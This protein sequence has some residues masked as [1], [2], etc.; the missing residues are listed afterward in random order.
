[1]A[2][3]RIDPLFER[4]LAKLDATIRKRTA[5]ALER[6]VANPARVGA[7]FERIEGT[8][9]RYWS[10]RVTLNFRIVLRLERD[11]MGDVYAAMDVGPHDIYRRFTG[12]S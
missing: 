11:D 3:L 7:N 9:G 10:L 6:F 8:D 1:M 12:R 4:R 2:R 5:N